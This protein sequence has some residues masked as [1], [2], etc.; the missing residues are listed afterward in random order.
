MIRLSA[1]HEG[2][3]IIIEIGD[4]GRGLNTAKIK[5]KALS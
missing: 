1:F 4:D 3:H 2:G 5:A